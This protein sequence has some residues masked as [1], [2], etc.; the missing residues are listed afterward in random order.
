MIYLR[1]HQMG[2][3][4]DEQRMCFMAVLEFR[5]LVYSKYNNESDFAKALGWPRQR[6]NKISAGKKVP[7]LL[8]LDDMAASLNVEPA[9]LLDIFLSHASPNRQ[10]MRVNTNLPSGFKN[11][12]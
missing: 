5:G 7:S 1:R 6:L 3:Y 10:R 11:T 8:E 4:Q 9:Y 2:Y 12:G